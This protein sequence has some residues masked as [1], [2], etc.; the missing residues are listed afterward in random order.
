MHDEIPNGLRPTHSP[1]PDDLPGTRAGNFVVY[2]AVPGFESELIRELGPSVR[3]VRESLVL[4][5]GPAR[6]AA[7]ARN[8]WYEPRW[9]TVESIGDAAR[10]LKSIQRNWA[11][12]TVGHHRRARLVAEKL[13]PVKARPQV[14]GTP[15]PASPLGSWTLWEP[16]LVLASP[17]CASP[18]PNGEWRFEEDR[19]G[20]PSRA[21]LKLWEA[22]SRLGEY[23]RPGELCLDLGSSPGGWT[24]AAAHCGANVF[25]IDK[26]DLDPDVARMA[27]VQH[28][29]GSAFGLDPRHAGRVDWLLSDVICYPARLLELVQRWIELGDVRRMVCTVKFQGETDFDALRGFTEIP[30][31]TLV[32]LFH[33]KHELTFFWKEGESAE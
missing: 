29:V 2:H 20:P 7:W 21:Y 5:E 32:H 15:P 16:N 4:A 26:A 11:L 22:L 12:W 25:S 31:S 9:I 13:P 27:R 1:S 10:T 23:P 30:G 8:V 24:W 6:H 28:C 18:F 19:E 33:N 14:F 3:E 17:R